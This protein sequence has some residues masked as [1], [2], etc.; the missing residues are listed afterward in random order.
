MRSLVKIQEAFGILESLL[1]KS[2]ELA[3]PLSEVW[4]ALLDARECI[5]YQILDSKVL[6]AESLESEL[7]DILKKREARN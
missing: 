1:S 4:N 3:G 7:L 5:L 6:G 2:D